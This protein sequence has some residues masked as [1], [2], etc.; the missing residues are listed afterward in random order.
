MTDYTY[1]TG[2]PAT[3]NNPSVDQPNMAVN[4]NSINNIIGEDHYTFNDS[5]GGMHQWVRMPV[6]GSIP[7]VLMSGQG[8]IYTKTRTTTTGNNEGSLFFTSDNNGHEY[9]LTRTISPSFS[10]FANAVGNGWTFLPGQ[11][12]YEY[13][14]ATKNTD[15]TVLFAVPFSTGVFAINC[16]VFQN[17][18]NRAFIQV[19]TSSLSGF[20]VASRDSSGNDTSNTFYWTAIGI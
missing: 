9:Q 18:N 10:T 3:N 8:T 14:V 7:P 16:T 17:S 15:G 20:T 6:I 12:L 13:G 1:T 11:L 4:T 19:K 2:I 5:R